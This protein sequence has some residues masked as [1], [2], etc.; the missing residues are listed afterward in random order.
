TASGALPLRGRIQ[1]PAAEA[2]DPN[3]VYIAESVYI[4]EHDQMAG[5]ARNNGSWQEFRF[6]NGSVSNLQN[7]GSVHMFDP[8]IFAWQAE[9][10]DVHIAELVNTDEGGPGVNGY[11]F[12]ASKATDIGQGFYRYDYAVMNFNSNQAVGSFS[13]PAVTCDLS[14]LGFHDVDHHSGSPWENTDWTASTT[15]NAPSWTTESYA[16]NPNANA[17]RWDMMYN[18]SFESGAA[19]AASL[20]S[21]NVGLFAPGVGTSLTADVIVPGDVCTGCTGGSFTPYCSANG[22][23]A[24]PAGAAFQINGTPNVV[25]NDLEFVVTQLPTG[26]FGYFIMAPN[27]ASGPLTNS[28]GNLCLGAGIVRWN[29]NQYILNSGI[30]GFV[31]LQPDLNNGPFGMQFMPGETWNFQYWYR[32]LNPNSTSNTTAGIQVQFC[33]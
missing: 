23:S 3:S 11:I 32:D 14:N 33:Q 27:Q 5:N 10:P 17:I 20:G 16:S 31:T 7:V 8:A 28:Q 13:L 15:G 22:N 29:E 9:H 21:A 19:P 30:F 6:V 18:F 2:A 24:N 4:S 25:A 12:V 26:Q 1:I